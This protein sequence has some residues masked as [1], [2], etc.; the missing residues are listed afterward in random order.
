MIT[1]IED[2]FSRGCGRCERFVTPNCS[3]RQWAQ[4]LRR[5]RA[6]LKEAMGYAEAGIR[7]PR[8]PRDVELPPELAD[9]LEADVEL[10]EAFHALTPGRQRS[11]VIH[12]NS[13]RKSE[14]RVSR[15][16]ALRSRI[17]AGKG[18]LER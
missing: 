9:A 2:Y 16:E 12:L 7:P 8:E 6:Y 15:I 11:H 10:A 18:A 4:G 13:A 14:T 1:D 5:L 3:A 17:L